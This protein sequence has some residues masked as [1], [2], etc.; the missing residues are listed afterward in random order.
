MNKLV[1]DKS[2]SSET[3]W[4]VLLFCV[5]MAKG[6]AGWGCARSRRTRGF[7]VGLIASIAVGGLIFG[8]SYLQHYCGP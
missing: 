4:I 5:P 3:I 2:P 1:K 6:M 7:G 8:W